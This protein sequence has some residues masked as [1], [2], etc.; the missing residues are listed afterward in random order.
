[1]FD[2]KT[3]TTLQD[4]YQAPFSAWRRELRPCVR[5]EFSA[6]IGLQKP[7]TPCTRRYLGTELPCLRVGLQETRLHPKLDTAAPR[8]GGLAIVLRACCYER[9]DDD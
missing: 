4:A 6:C 2:D 7:C 1:M 3:E 9:R 5:S 8:L